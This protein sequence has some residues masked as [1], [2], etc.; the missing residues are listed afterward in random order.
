MISPVEDNN[1]IAEKAR[2]IEEVV[3]E[4]VDHSD[5]QNY[6]DRSRYL[7]RL[8]SRHCRDHQERHK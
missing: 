2:T 1:D 7:H 4:N 8:L 5:D 3:Q 6:S